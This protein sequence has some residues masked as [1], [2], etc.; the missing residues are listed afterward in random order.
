MDNEETGIEL[1]APNIVQRATATFYSWERRGRGWLVWGYPVEPEPPFDLFYGHEDPLYV[2]VDDG[3]RPTLLSS[4]ADKIKSAFKPAKSSDQL[5]AQTALQVLPPEPDESADNYG[6]VEIGVSLPSDQKISADFAE[7][8]LLSLSYSYHPV[9]FEIIGTSDSILLQLVC[10]EPDAIQ[11]KQQFKAYFPNVALNEQEEFLR[12]RLDFSKETVIADFGLSQEFMRPL[13]IFRG[14]EL[15]PLISIIGALENLEAGEI[16]VLQVIFKA[17]RNPWA[18]SIIRSVVDWQGKPFF[19]DAPEMVYL[20]KEKIKSPLFAAV[21]RVIGQS[22]KLY[23]AWEIVRT[24]GSGLI[25]LAEPQSNELIPLNN[26]YYNDVDHSIDVINR[27]THRSGVILNSKELVSLVHLPSVSVQ[28]RKL[29]RDTLKSKEAP[30]SVIGHELT[31]GENVHQ[32]KRTLVSLDREQRLRHM[33]IIGAT[34]TGKST[35]LLNMIAQDIESGNGLAVLDPH[36][37]L[38]DAILGLV[39]EQR[40]DDVVLL[41]PFDEEYPVG[42]NILS[43]NSEIEKNVMASDL[44]EVFRRL[45]TSWGDQMTSVLSNAI[46]AFLESETGGT[47]LELRRFLIEKEFRNQFLRTVKD[48]QVVYYWHKEFPLLVGK[49]VGPVLTRLNTFLRPKI[50]RNMVAQ[51]QGLNFDEILNTKKIFLA[52]LAQGLIGEENAYLLGTLLVSKLHQVAMARQAKQVEE[53]EDYYFYIDEFQNFVTPSMSAILSGARK[54]RLGLILA[55]QEL[56]Q[57]WNRDTEVA[58]SVI[59]NPGTRI[60][61][62]LGDFDSKKLADGF[63]HFDAYDLQNLGVGEAIARIDRMEHDFNL[64]TFRPP[65][66]DQGKLQTRQKELISRS[67]K[68]YGTPKARIEESWFKESALTIEVEKPVAVKVAPPVEQEVVP[69]R[70]E[71]AKEKVERKKDQPNPIE[72]TPSP[73]NK[74]IARVAR[75]EEGK[76]GPQHR[77]LQSLIKRIAEEK[78]YKA[79]IEKELPDGAGSVDVGLEKDSYKLA[80]EISI[81]TSEVQELGNIRK[82]LDAGYDKVVLCSPVKKT[83][84][85]VQT[86]LADQLEEDDQKKVLLFAPEEFF[87]YLEEEAAKEASK[88]EKVKGYKV[89]VNYTAVQEDEKKQKREAISKVIMQ[90]LKRK[91]KDR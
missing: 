36:G 51:K 74:Q 24:V 69:P 26:D 28:S 78:G 34:G 70:P 66:I 20:A 14:F 73:V 65:Q 12:N 17:V 67:R 59:S 41:D 76:G 25:T 32:G 84:A 81:T 85:K 9:S 19:V 22:D 57:L 16:G 53:R 38:I 61:F 77:Y 1:Y 35:F 88:V 21:I 37:D 50:I 91:T 58:N 75:T 29:Q 80:C 82:C 87:F 31:L 71:V 72:K 33:Y 47:L 4:L 39:P 10:R 40:F 46:L 27:T 55:H 15:D 45:S 90:A 56:R 60:C 68:R 6:L 23:R 3:K 79:T 49:P 64:Q 52:K 83:L 63:A 44:V 43:A 11:V 89:K 62:R 7:Q 5:A 86:L 30:P 18:E 13:R 42:L 48:P 2:S 54:Y 8:L